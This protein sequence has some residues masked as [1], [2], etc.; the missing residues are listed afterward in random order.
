MK[1]KSFDIFKT[2]DSHAATEVLVENASVGKKIP[3]SSLGHSLFLLF[4]I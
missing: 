2:T 4:K 1:E 3:G